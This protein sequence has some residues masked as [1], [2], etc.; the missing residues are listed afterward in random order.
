MGLFSY[1]EET[2]VKKPH[3]AMYELSL[4][5][6]PSQTTINNPKKKPSFKSPKVKVNLKKNRKTLQKKDD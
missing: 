6:S 2:M 5:L 1:K 3:C 4:A